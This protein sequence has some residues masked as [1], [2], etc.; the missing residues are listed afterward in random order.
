MKRNMRYVLVIGVLSYGW[1]VG[2]QGPKASL[3]D[4]PPTASADPTTQG[5]F[6]R[7][8]ADAKSE[9]WH[10]ES[11]DQILQRVGEA[12]IGQPYE[13]G[14]LDKP[15]DETL[16]VSLESFDCVLYVE[17]V[18]AL[19]QG[20]AKEDYRF[21]T[22]EHH[23]Q[24]LRYRDGHLEG[25][26]SRLHY[27]SEWIHNNEARHTVTNITEAIG[28]EA[29]DKQLTFMSNHRDNYPRFAT[30][31]SLFQGIRQMEADLANLELFYIPQ[32]RIRTVYEHLQAGDIIA[33]A[34]HIE[35]LDVTHTG[36]VHRG[37]DGTVGFMHASTSGGVKV[38][39]DL[40]AYIENNRV[41]V[42]IVVARPT[43]PRAPKRDL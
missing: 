12:F 27:F 30:N 15:E 6:N 21:G 18:L 31:D 16:I 19:A 24:A 28:G 5:L 20:I 23:L 25:Y 1:L 35:G 11:F 7:V 10:A 33:T 40:Q 43:D 8:M 37:A 14:M 26:C 13:A 36:F 39:P 29:F 22:F 34:T 42:G 32:D 41:Q 17:A 9:T 2:C 3:S 4:M 38:S